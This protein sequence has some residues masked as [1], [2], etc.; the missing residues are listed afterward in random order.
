[1]ES[2]AGI[3][4]G[5]DAVMDMPVSPM[6]RKPDLWQP[7]Q[8]VFWLL[9]LLAAFGMVSMI[10]SLVATE[11]A[12]EVWMV[13]LVA[14]ALQT[15]VLLWV[16]RILP[17][18]RSQSL[19]LRLGAFLLGSL[20]AIGLAAN[21]NGE[22]GGFLPAYGL[23]NFQA[24]ISAPI[25]EDASRMICVI[26][27]LALAVAARGTLS[28]MDGVVYGFLV[29]AGFEV[30]ENLLY[31]MRAD[32]LADALQSAVMR[33]LM[34]FGL[35]AL[36]TAVAAGALAYVWSRVLAGQSSRW[37]VIVPAYLLP[38]LLHMGW[39]APG[40]YVFPLFKFVEWILL[41]LLTIGAFVA[42]VRWGRLDERRRYGADGGGSAGVSKAAAIHS[43]TP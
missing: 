35:H 37:W 39:D 32:A 31:A 29:G 7:R 25:T 38:M 28:V 1:M 16:A 42:V 12:L 14:F 19:S 5:P 18:V 9:L 17:R 21:I 3:G 34:G 23:K 10:L 33:M 30:F 8:P 6:K 20:G 24:A 15:A 40:I 27:I 4:A 41:Y 36:W 2:N 11:A 13:A 26:A 43:Q 22:Y